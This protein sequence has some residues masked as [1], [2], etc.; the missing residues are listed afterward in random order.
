VGTMRG[1]LGIATLGKALFYA[2]GG[3]AYGGLQPE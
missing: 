1:R 3:L 2:T